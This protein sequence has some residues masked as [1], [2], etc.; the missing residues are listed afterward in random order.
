MWAES[1]VFEISAHPYLAPSPVL[2]LS[3]KMKFEIN[4]RALIRTFTVCK[5]TADTVNK[6]LTYVNKQLT[7]INKQLAYV[8]KQLTL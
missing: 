7:Y 8:N 5:Q 2:A 3:Q 6:Q 1:T 4:A